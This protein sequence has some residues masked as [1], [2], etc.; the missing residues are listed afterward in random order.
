MHQLE[1][2]IATRSVL[3][4]L[5]KVEQKI[6]DYSIFID[7]NYPKLDYF[8]NAKLFFLVNIL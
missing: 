4:N 2:D 5:K 7:Q 8:L 1:Y 6:K 3:S